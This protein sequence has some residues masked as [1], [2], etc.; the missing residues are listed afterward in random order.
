MHTSPLDPPGAGD[1]GGLNVYVAET[2][3][4]LARSGIEVDVFTR[5]THP[6]G[7]PVASPSAGV[8]VH[9]LPAGPPTGLRKE[10]LPGQ[11]CAFTSE[12]LRRAASQEP[13]DVVHTHYWLS[14][15]AGWLAAE[16]WGVPLIHTM[17]TNAK[18][19]NHRLA[20]SDTPE[21]LMRVVGEEQLASVADRLVANTATERDELIEL[22]DAD[23]GK[24]RVVHPGVDLGRFTPGD[25]GR[26]RR[27]F[28]W[29]PDK[30]LLLF[31]GR[32]Q[33]LK[34]P[35]L[36]IEAAAEMV[37]ADPGLRDRLQVVICGGLSGSG[38]A[39]PGELQAMASALA[40]DDIVCFLPPVSRDEL[41]DLYRAAD[42]VV[43]P[44]YS[45]SFGLVA[46]EAQAC[47]TPVVAAAV[48]GLV[49]SVADGRSGLLIDGHDPRD[50][51]R[52]LAELLRQPRL[53]AALSGAARGHAEQFSWEATAAG[54]ALVYTDALADRG[55][56][57]LE[58]AN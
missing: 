35:E 7:P 38:M 19:K 25:R 47:G 22:Y 5:A 3:R 18:V 44:S 45:E 4:L 39:R 29:A 56:R 36:L 28:G 21:P 20:T 2:S 12:L 10:D 11:V 15:Q 52:S 51:S 34:A 57:L 54:T 17:H 31:V 58:T 26:A 14:G 46:L 13:Y 27:R 48:G 43:V 49:T 37:A 53:L 16:R 23:P 32:I 24:V 42:A 41:P 50:W 9:A 30:Q 33:P 55:L 8:T 40:V 6:Q 1:A